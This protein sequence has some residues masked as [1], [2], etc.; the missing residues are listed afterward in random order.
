MNS[1]GAFLIVFKSHLR[2]YSFK[3]N[4]PEYNRHDRAARFRSEAITEDAP[5]VCISIPAL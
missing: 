1:S 5:D 4:K 3:D 2:G